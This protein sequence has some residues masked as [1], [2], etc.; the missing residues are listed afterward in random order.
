MDSVIQW[1]IAGIAAIV[2]PLLTIFDLP[3]NTLMFLTGVGMAF[4]CE[5]INPDLN[6]MLAMVIVYL[7]GE[8]WEFFVSLF[9]IRR[10]KVSW[11]AVFCIGLGGFVGTII[12]TGLFPVLGSF[13]GGVVGAFLAA[14]LYEYIHSGNS[15]N[16]FHIAWAAAKMRCF[17][18][19]G[20]LVAGMVLAIMLVKIII[21]R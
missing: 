4:L 21:L 5:N 1:I 12:G 19:L 11:F 7:M 13:A 8:C 20:K 14:F 2:G 15:K 16:A 18:L 3:G 6:Y 17:A 9:G 10:E